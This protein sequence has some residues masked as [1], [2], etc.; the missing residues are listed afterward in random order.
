MKLFRVLFGLTLILGVLPFVPYSVARITGSLPSAHWWYHHGGGN[1]GPWWGSP[2]ELL[3]YTTLFSLVIILP[4][5][6]LMVAGFLSIREQKA[7]AL[8]RGVGLSLL[9]WA[10]AF[11]QL[12]VMFWTVD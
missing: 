1:H 11:A 2:F 9:Q 4:G 7:G 8:F 12:S 3:L 10:L 6:T 5:T